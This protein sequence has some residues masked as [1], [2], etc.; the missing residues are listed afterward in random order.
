MPIVPATR[1]GIPSQLRITSERA[2]PPSAAHIVPRVSDSSGARAGRL[3]R[4]R[5]SRAGGAWPR[6]RAGPDDRPVSALMSSTSG[7]KANMPGRRLAAASTT[8][9]MPSSSSSGG[10]ARTRVTDASGCVRRWR[11]DRLRRKR[12]QRPPGPLLIWTGA[13]HMGL[14]T[15]GTTAVDWEERYRTDRLREERLARITHELEQS[16]LGALLCFDMANIRY[17]TATHIGTWAADKLNRFC[18]LPQ[19][20]R[21]DHVG[22]RLGRPPSRAL[23]PLARRRALALGNLDDARSDAAGRRPGGERRPQDPRRAR[24]A[25]AAGRAPRAST[26]WSPRCCS[27]SRPR[28]S[29]SSTVSS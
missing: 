20:R 13:G 3:A 29:K 25:R 28:A 23:Q 8:A 2:S 6:G 14:H 24:G 18:L 17:V 10:A 5:R 27:R 4:T 9:R 1:P 7:P 11:E 19:G 15:Y 21:A 12:L 16:S 26:R 22:L